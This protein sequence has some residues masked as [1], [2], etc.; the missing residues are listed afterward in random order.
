MTQL[1]ITLLLLL[2]TPLFLLA[3]PKI[4]LQ[5]LGSGG[6]E[7]GDKRA[8]SGYIVWINGKSRVLV[9]FGGGASLRF[10]E[11]GAKIEDL[12]IILL[13]HLHI[14]HT[15]DL[16]ALLKS[17]FFIKRTK[18]LP[19]YGPAQNNFMPG[20]ENFI[21]RLFANNKGAWEYMGDY[22]DGRAAFQLKA[23]TIAP[24]KTVKTIYKQKDLAVQAITVHHGPIPALA[25]RV[26]AG[27]KSITFSGDMNGDYH[28][29]EKL[30][31]GTD[32]LVAHNAVPKGATGAGANLHMTPFTIGKIAQNAGVKSLVLSHRM[33]RTLKKGSETKREIRKNY[34]G[35]VKFA[36]DLNLY[37][38]R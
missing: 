23:H 3:Q 4:T 14:D 29:L 25:Y 30:A 15:A 7:S 16:P 28:T 27:S 24:T 13:T 17:S 10:E 18:D 22:L 11:A 33:L 21:E 5:V 8:S 20:T 31:K 38:I 35:P 37:R 34:R 6:P 19:I 32:I 2:L 1:K 26:T 12:D 36:N 9:D